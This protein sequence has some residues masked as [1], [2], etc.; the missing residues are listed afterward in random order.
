[1]EINI[2]AFQFFKTNENKGTIHNYPFEV[3]F[4]A[5][6][7]AQLSSSWVLKLILFTILSWNPQHNVVRNP[8]NLR[9][10]AVPKA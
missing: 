10:W 9:E 1:M 4:K 8:E 3:V 6:G 7:L 5:K 2:P